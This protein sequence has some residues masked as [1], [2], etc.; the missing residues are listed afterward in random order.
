MLRIV[1]DGTPEAA[2]ELARLEH[3]GESDFERVE[4]A[5]REILSAVRK[6]GDAAVLRYAEK[7]DKRRPNPLH[8]TRFDGEGAL[9]RLPEKARDAMKRAADRIRSFHEKQLAHFIDKPTFRYTD[10]DGVTLGWRA[11]PMARAGVY[12]PGGKARYPSSV[13]M[14]AIPAHVAGVGEI[15]L[16]TPLQGDASES[17]RAAAGG[18]ATDDALLA[19]AHL[20]GVKSIVDAGGAQ[21]IAAL[22][23][24]T[25]TIP[26]VDKIVGP[27]NLYVACAKR[28]VFGAVA[29]DSIAGPSEILVVADDEADPRLVAADLLSQAEHDEAA[30]PLLVCSSPNMAES[31]ATELEAQLQTLPRAAIARASVDTNGIAIVA[32]SRSRLAELADALAPEHLSLQVRDPDELLRS[33]IRVGAAFLGPLTPEAAGDYAAGPSHVLPTGG[34]VRFGS[35]LN[36]LDFFAHSSLISYTQQALAAHSELIT[37]LARLEGLEAHARAVEA[38]LSGITSSRR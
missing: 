11:R 12:A 27:G 18:H 33:V 19:A 21:A 35:P 16:A 24:G 5:V 4:P 3:R 2:R 20:S 9:A 32:R 38:R 17:A 25:E 37:E 6:E 34:T 26:R 13:L 29:I 30:Y 36:V 15:I 28:F 22:A 10:A 8:I 7:F 31:V 1:L 23:Y 14:S